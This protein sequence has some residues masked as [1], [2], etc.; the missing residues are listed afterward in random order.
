MQC[1]F[2]KHVQFGYNNLLICDVNDVT[3]TGRFV[4]VYRSPNSSLPD[5]LECLSDVM[6]QYV[7]V[8]RNVFVLGD[9]NINFKDTTNIYSRRLS[10]LMQSYGLKQKVSDFT[11]VDLRSKT[12]IDLVFTNN[13]RIRTTVYKNDLIADHMT[14]GIFKENRR[15]NRNCKKSIVDRSK[16]SAALMAHEMNESLDWNVISVLNFDEVTIC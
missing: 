13:E 3:Y 1:T 6:E 14:V 2:V 4:L 15:I 5:F 9:F 7:H 10:R 12:L 8:Q 16:Y 11:R